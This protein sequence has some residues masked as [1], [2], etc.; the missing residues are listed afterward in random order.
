MYVCIY[1]Y[2][3]MCIHI[4][5]PYKNPHV[6]FFLGQDLHEAFKLASLPSI[7]KHVFFR[8][9]FLL[10]WWHDVF[11]Q[12]FVLKWCLR[13]TANPALCAIGWSPWMKMEVFQPAMWSFTSVTTAIH[14]GIGSIMGHILKNQAGFQARSRTGSNTALYGMS[15]RWCEA[16]FLYSL[17]LFLDPCCWHDLWHPTFSSIPVLS[18]K[19][20]GVYSADR[21][22]RWLTARCFEG[23]VP[24]EEKLVVGS[25]PYKDANHPFARADSRLVIAMR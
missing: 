19:Q 25:V 7:L 15:Q 10:F 11:F 4:L 3:N 14:L 12:A 21:S 17:L 23:P 9:F 13:R 16:T 2:N 1:I 5:Y 18:Y 8:F 24:L 6:P 22:A 20:G